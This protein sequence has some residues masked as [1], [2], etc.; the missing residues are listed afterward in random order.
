[1]TKKEQIDEAQAAAAAR[2][3]AE[4]DAENAHAAYCAARDACNK[5]ANKDAATY[6]EARDYFNKAAEKSAAANHAAK[7]ANQVW[8]AYLRNCKK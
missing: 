3:T 2:D 4:K 5:A 8:F 6:F 1:M 7:V